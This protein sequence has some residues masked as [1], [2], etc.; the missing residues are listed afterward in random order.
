MTHPFFADLPLPRVFAHRGLMTAELAAQ[1]VVENSLAA[2]TAAVDAGAP[3]VESDC[4]LTS[5]GTVVLFHDGDLS[6][7][8]G[9][10]RRIPDLAHA[11]LRSLMADRGG[12]LT[13]D[14]VLQRFPTTRFNIDVKSD[15]VAEPAGRIL[16]QY[17][18]RVL[19][20]SFDDRRRHRALAAAVATRGSA[21]PA[22]S[23]GRAGLLKVLLAV[24]SGSRRLVARRLAELDALQVPER[25]GLVRVFTPRLVR[26]AHAHG[27]EVHVWTVNEVE[28]MRE[29][30]RH[31]ADGII[32]DRADVALAAF[33]QPI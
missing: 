7:V 6:R 20:T 3:Y 16:G 9:D 21:R 13:L 19:L 28:R 29:L 11:D 5:D 23:P 14:E 4:H 25:Y 31:G 18:A 30:V 33:T 2:V 22:T 27:V 15:A 24:A 10:P 17:G 26:A 1:G 12:L 32:T 8:L